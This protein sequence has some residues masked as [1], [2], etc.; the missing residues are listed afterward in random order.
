MSL[1]LLDI[2]LNG[3]GSSKDKEKKKQEDSVK[4]DPVPVK[5]VQ[6]VNEVYMANQPLYAFVDISIEGQSITSFTDKF[7]DPFVSFSMKRTAT[8]RTG[9]AGSKF[10]ISLYDDSALAVESLISDSF[11]KEGKSDVTIRYGWVGPSGRV[12]VSTPKMKGQIMDYSLSLEGVNTTL[13]LD[14]ALKATSQAGKVKTEDYPALSKD[15]KTTSYQGKPSEVVK[16]IA[17]E[18]GW[19]I[20]SITETKPML[21]DD[22]TVKTFS[23]KNQSA[24]DFIKKELCEKAESTDGIVGY[25]FYFDANGAVHFDPH[26]DKSQ[27]KVVK[28]DTSVGEIVPGQVPKTTTKTLGAGNKL[29]G[30]LSLDPNL[31]PFKLPQNVDTGGFCD[32]GKVLGNIISPDITSYTNSLGDIFDFGKDSGGSSIGTSYP[33]VSSID[34]SVYDNT[35]NGTY[36]SGG[37]SNKTVSSVGKVTLIGGKHIAKL[38]LVSSTNKFQVKFIHT[39]FPDIDWYTKKLAEQTNSATNGSRVCILFDYSTD[40]DKIKELINTYSP[41]LRDKG[42]Q[43]VLL[44]YP[45]VFD[46]KIKDGSI[47]NTMIMQFNKEIT[48]SLDKNVVFLDIYSKL[49]SRVHSYTTDE[50]GRYYTT[51]VYQDLFNIIT[52]TSYSNREYSEN[53]KTSSMQSDLGQLLSAGLSVASVDGSN[54]SK[55]LNQ[56]MSTMVGS[57][58]GS[59]DSIKKQAE[60]ILNQSLEGINGGILSDKDLSD[61]TKVYFGNDSSSTISGLKSLASTESTLKSLGISPNMNLIG[62]NSLITTKKEDSGKKE[63]EDKKASS[64]PKQIMAY[65]EYNTGKKNSVVKSFNA[66]FKGKAIAGTKKANRNLSIDAVRNEMLECVI[67]GVQGSESD[68]GIL[69]PSQYSIMGMSSSSYDNLEK[70]AVSLWN[71][72]Y[73]Q[74]YPATLE[75]MGNP[76]IDV[77]Q[78]IK[79]AVFTKYGFLHHTSG[80]YFVKSVTDSISGGQY[81]T[82]LELNKNKEASTSTGKGRDSATTGG[83]SGGTG[84]GK[85]AGKANM[86][87]H[88]GLAAGTNEWLGVTMDNG[89]NGC[90]EAVDKIGSYYSPFLKEEYDNGVFYV[91]TLCEDA[92]AK[93]ILVPYSSGDLTEGDVIVYG[94]FDHVVLSTGGAGYVGNSTSQV[95]VVQGGDYTAMGGLEP[96]YIIKTSQA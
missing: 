76:H 43:L 89:A 96:T 60:G 49:K 52:T 45:P 94:D 12:F 67:Q 65:Y 11:A 41:K 61:L 15:G 79:I 91:P 25:T 27:A 33:T 31:D 18:E 80:L 63:K 88:D 95:K 24:T 4:T 62:G 93:G 40:T 85:S 28:K 39:D 70:C 90:V 55:M 3:V 29:I 47:S 86:N 64:K 82:S 16:A 9:Y 75:V 53:G 74:V 81:T 1:G 32:I 23:R 34:Y 6:Y 83:A 78:W 50:T 36:V 71:R 54:Y 13:E 73:T 56:I 14:G 37:E 72:Y 20:A 42:S 2:L 68:M 92:K 58:T 35:K 77:G 44:S 22:G 84:A 59:L 87:V 19:E 57:S 51:Q 30:D 5:S 26:A 38:E 48:S 21:N 46:S 17:K 8:A 69:N 66:E 10:Q 7:D